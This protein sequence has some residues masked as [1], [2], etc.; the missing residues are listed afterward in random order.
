MKPEQAKER[1][2]IAASH[3]TRTG[4]HDLYARAMRL[5]GERH[6]K[7]ELVDL[8]T[9]LLT[10]L[11]NLHRQEVH[12]AFRAGY[13][14]AMMCGTSPVAVTVASAWEAYQ[15]SLSSRK[16]EVHHAYSSTCNCVSCIHA[17]G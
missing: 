3:P 11:D 12:H 7:G 10:D 17:E 9:W 2:A 14:T 15:A 8:V 16:S 6:A 5:V 1:E 13:K 4:R